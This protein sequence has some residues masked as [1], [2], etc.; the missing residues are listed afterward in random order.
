MPRRAD[1]VPVRSGHG[2]PA[3]T[4]PIRESE[5]GGLRD[6]VSTE[7]VRGEPGRADDSTPRGDVSGDGLRERGIHSTIVATLGRQGGL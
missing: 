1:Q 6:A 7:S 5:I 4:H 3:A 2:D